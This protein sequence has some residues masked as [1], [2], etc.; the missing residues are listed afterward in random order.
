VLGQFFEI[1]GLFQFQTVKALSIVGHLIKYRFNNL[2]SA[3]ANFT[4]FL[5]ETYQDVSF[6]LLKAVWENL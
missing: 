6:A 4:I 3:N 5:D 1:H 2:A